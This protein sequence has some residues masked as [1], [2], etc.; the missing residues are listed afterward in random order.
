M[1]LKFKE[2]KGRYLEASDGS[3][4]SIKDVLFDDQSWKIRYL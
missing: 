1:V 4:G 3:I 2:V